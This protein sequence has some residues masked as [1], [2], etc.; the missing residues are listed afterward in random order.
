MLTVE[1]VATQV[2]RN[3]ATLELQFPRRGSPRELLRE[4]EAV[5]SAFALTKNRVLAGMLA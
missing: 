1:G 2:W 3:G 5:R 4:F